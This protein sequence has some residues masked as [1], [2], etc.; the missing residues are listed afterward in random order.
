M[1]R[2]CPPYGAKV[3]YITFA[4]QDKGSSG[5][6]QHWGIPGPQVILE[7]HRCSN[8]AAGAP[9]STRVPVSSNCCHGLLALPSVFR[10][11]P[12][13]SKV[14]ALTSPTHVM[15]AQASARA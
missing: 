3:L 12:K 4:I 1:A 5:C 7:L 10:S 15:P 9:P 8:M 6:G 2:K 13:E 11:L 14:A